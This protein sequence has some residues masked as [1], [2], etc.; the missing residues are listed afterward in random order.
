MAANASVVALSAKRGARR[1]PL[2][3]KFF[4]A[5]RK[6]VIEDDE[7]LTGIWIPYSNEVRNI[8]HCPPSWSR[9]LLFSKKKKTSSV[10]ACCVNWHF[11]LMTVPWFSQAMSIQK[12]NSKTLLRGREE[13]WFFFLFRYL[14]IFVRCFPFPQREFRLLASSCP[15]WSKFPKSWSIT[16]CHVFIACFFQLVHQ[17]SKINTLF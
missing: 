9:C 7:I 12:L 3:Q 1:V 13:Q 8:L 14:R 4:V 6:T 17:F 2:D 10:Y 5:Y 16:A 11:P 15:N